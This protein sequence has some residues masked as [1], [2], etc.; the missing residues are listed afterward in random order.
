MQ[1]DYDQGYAD[2]RES[3]Q[4]LIDAERQRADL[5]RQDLEHERTK[6]DRLRKLLYAPRIGTECDVPF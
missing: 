4:Y 3:M 2:G 6:V 5:A 1:E